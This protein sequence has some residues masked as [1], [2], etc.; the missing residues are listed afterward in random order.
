MHTPLPPHRAVRSGHLPIVS[1]LLL[2]HGAVAV[3]SPTSNLTALHIACKKGLTAIAVCLLNNLPALL[4]IDDSPKETSLHIVAR[5]GHT[6]I[7]RNLLAIAHQAEMLRSGDASLRD[8][9]AYLYNPKPVPMNDCLPE[10]SLDVLALSVEDR[11]TP[12]HEAAANGHVEIVKMIVKFLQE[13]HACRRDTL[14]SSL[15][16]GATPQKAY[17][18]ISPVTATPTRA[19]LSPFASPTRGSSKKQAAVPGIDMLTLKGCTPFHEA[20]KAGHFEV[21]SVLL[22]A[23]ADINA[24][25]RP[26]LDT[27]VNADLSALVYACLNKKPDIVRFLLQHNATDAR[28]KALSRT[29]RKQ[30]Y[31]IVGLLLCYN[32]GVKPTPVSSRQAPPTEDTPLQLSISW[33]S[34][35]LQFVRSEWLKMVLIEAPRPKNRVGVISQLDVSSNALTRLPIEVFRLTE[36]IQLDFSR[37]QITELPFVDE[38]L[39]GGWTCAKLATVD[40]SSNQLHSLPP[41]LFALDNL[42][43]LNVNCNKVDRIPSSVWTAPKLTKL[44]LNH[45]SLPSFPTHCV[46]DGNDSPFWGESISNPPTPG[47]G[48]SGGGNIGSFSGISPPDSGYKSSDPKDS[49]TALDPIL[50]SLDLSRNPLSSTPFPSLPY[51]S[52]VG[53]TAPRGSPSLLEKHTHTQSFVSRRFENFHDANV[54]VEEFEDLEEEAERE[55]GDIFCL[56]VLDLS[57]N[58]LTAVPLGLSCLAPRLQK[59]NVSHNSIKSLGVISDYPP[60]VELLDACNNELHSA[61]AHAIGDTRSMSVCARKCIGA[62][63][64]SSLY[65]PSTPVFAYK[66]CAHKLHKNLRK[67]STLKLNSNQLVDVQLFRFVTR[68]REF[69][70]SV[71]ESMAFKVRANTAD[72]AVQIKTTPGK[73]DISRSV[74]IPRQISRK[75]PTRKSDNSPSVRRASEIVTTPTRTEGSHSGSSSSQEG[76]GSTPMSP[77]SAVTPLY[78]QLSTLELARNKLTSVP[79]HVHLMSNLSCLVVSHNS[80]IDTLPLELSTLEHLWNLE[81][82]GCPLTNPPVGDL[83]KFRLASDK[84]MYMRSL[85]HE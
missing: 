68:S 43:E 55:P 66:P 37:N 84:L 46:L 23:G 67:L 79:A 83:D 73:V 9:G 61:V 42:K 6:D 58:K 15:T 69:T 54:E 33:N 2:S 5:D 40:G 13:C 44:H 75:D 22:E 56:E 4:A 39:N 62:A 24:F 48:G 16:T 80:A 52:L 57:H 1:S 34:R 45:N 81:Y 8:G 50:E 63:S 49:G 85:L 64:R 20:V 19:D 3:A 47:V 31:E 21:M 26:S 10:M 29:L 70:M 51:Q 59:L 60:D 12:L 17:S 27:K 35:N 36:L 53:G 72:T 77:A 30:F 78:P 41:S 7:M 14:M 82:E 65:E 11:K 28:L 18:P 76:S 74:Y 71:D 32:G 38:L 25:I